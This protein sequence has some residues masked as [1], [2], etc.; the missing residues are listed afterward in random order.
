MFDKWKR[1]LIPGGGPKSCRKAALSCPGP[2]RS[3]LSVTHK[4]NNKSPALLGSQED[5]RG[6][7]TFTQQKCS[8]KA[9]SYKRTDF[10]F[11]YLIH[12]FPISERFLSARG[13]ARP[14]DIYRNNERRGYNADPSAQPSSCLLT[15]RLFFSGNTNILILSNI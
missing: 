11:E 10:W 4:N 7:S 12:C 9:E 3:G 15:T 1:L 2:A 5:S 8:F 6:C 14:A 13:E